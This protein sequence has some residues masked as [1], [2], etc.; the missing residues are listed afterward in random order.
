[1][2]FSNLAARVVPADVSN[3]AQGRV[4]YGTHYNVCKITPHHMS[5]KLSAQRCGELFQNPTRDA[6]STYGIG[7]EGEIYGYVDEDDR[8]WTS[9]NWKND[10]QA[11]TIECSNASNSDPDWPLTNATWNSL[12]NLCVD[13]C[14]RYNFRLDYDG[15]PNGS[16]TRHNMFADTDCP[17]P[18]LERHL[19]ELAETVNKILDGGEPGP[20]P[21]GGDEPVRV[22]QNGNTPETVYADTD[23]K[24]K[25]GSLNP[26]EACD[27]F[28]EFNGRAM[29]RYKVD[30]TRNYKI[31]FCQ[32][33]GGII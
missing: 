24:I 12:I 25:I 2:G 21:G 4:K 1:M 18:W 5:G 19:P 27:C 31:G 29:V 6:S 23:L 16:L 20:T 14:R 3:Y 30:G 7:F 10:I 22:Y 26:R 9:S 15:T 13:I 17:G 32:W 8:P 33:L 28:G 11:I